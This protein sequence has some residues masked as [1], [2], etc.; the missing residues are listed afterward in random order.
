MARGFWFSRW[1]GSGTEADPFIP[2]VVATALAEFPLMRWRTIDLRPDSSQQAGW[3]LVGTGR[4]RATWEDK[5]RVW[6]LGT[7]LD[8][9]L[10]NDFVDAVNSNFGRS[11]PYGRTVRDLGRYVLRRVPVK[12]A[13]RPGRDGRFHVFLDAGEDTLLGSGLAV[14]RNINAVD[15]GVAVPVGM[16]VDVANS[17]AGLP[18]GRYAV[19]ESDGRY[20]RL[21]VDGSTVVSITSNGVCD[22]WAMDVPG[23]GDDFG[24]EDEPIGVT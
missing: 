23:V 22:L 18:D 7:S 21:T 17:T 5:P 11:Y 2:E 13:L 10:P 8:S 20:I 9:V 14:R 19:I 4:A 16:P 15:V 3:C 24:A 1:S 6:G 12:G